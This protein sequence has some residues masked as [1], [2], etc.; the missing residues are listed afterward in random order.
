MSRSGGPVPGGAPVTSA[1]R[2]AAAPASELAELQAGSSTRTRNTA[3][4]REPGGTYRV[5]RGD[6][7]YSI[8]R[9][10]GIPVNDLVAWN[11][12]SMPYSLSAGQTL[13]L[14][15]SAQNMENAAT[16]QTQSRYSDQKIDGSTASPANDGGGAPAL[17]YKKKKIRRVDGLSW[18]WPVEGKVI[19][20]FNASDPARR[21]IKIAGKSGESITAAESGEVVYSG[22]GLV[23]YGQLVIIKH[24]REYLSA[25]G[26]NRK[27]LVKEG[28]RVKRGAV[29]A[30]M[31]TLKD[32]PLLHFEIR[33][34]G[35]PV[36][37]VKY[38]P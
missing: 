2:P 10:Q 30:T 7:L 20:T 15:S 1:S 37:P 33:R 14:H 19:Q 22:D 24:S 32:K 16:T 34:K 21:G 29:I 6:T 18:Q 23:G 35:K 13:R 36:D 25:Y 8:S 9:S 31:G 26:H 3:T 5:R 38:L 27:R 28:Q 11:N 17:D 12:L 4:K